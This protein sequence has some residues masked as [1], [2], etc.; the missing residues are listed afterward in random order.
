MLNTIGSEK[1]QTVG[2]WTEYEFEVQTA[3]LYEI[4]LRY[5]QNEQTGMYTSRKVYIDGEVPFEEANYAK[6]NYD[7][8]WQVEP[9]GNGAD[10]FQFYLE[11]GKHILKLEVTLG[12]MGT[13]VRQVAQIVD[14]VNKDYLE[15]LKLTGPSPR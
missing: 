12:E 8:N 6:F 13:V 9:L 2:Q 7:T 5:R 14:S 4:V 10:T 11:P 1:W 15:I 3:G